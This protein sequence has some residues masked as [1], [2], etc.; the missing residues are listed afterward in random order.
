MRTREGQ[1]EEFTEKGDRAQDR[2][3]KQTLQVCCQLETTGV[4]LLESVVLCVSCHNDG[5]YYQ[6]LV[7]KSQRSQVLHCVGLFCTTRKSPTQN[8][9][10]T[11]LR[12]PSE[13]SL[14]TQTVGPLNNTSITKRSWGALCSVWLVVRT[15]TLT[16]QPFLA[17][18]FF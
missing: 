15:R 10:S 18:K 12:N 6:H 1:K 4:V 2:K 5:E 14:V 13:R 3:C 7:G 8:A 17:S 11:P 9:N 16:H